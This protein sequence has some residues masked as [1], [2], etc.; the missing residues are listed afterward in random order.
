MMKIITNDMKVSNHTIFTIH[1]KPTPLHFGHHSTLIFVGESIT[2]AMPY[3][4]QNLH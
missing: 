3:A 4:S 2:N 1:T